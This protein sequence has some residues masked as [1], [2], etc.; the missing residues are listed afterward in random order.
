MKYDKILVIR[1]DEIDSINQSI[2]S[3]AFRH[4][5]IIEIDGI[6]YTIWNITIISILRLTPSC[7]VKLKSTSDNTLIYGEI[8]LYL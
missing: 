4:I 1:D 6:S 8:L 5:S 2:I 7:N 3:Y